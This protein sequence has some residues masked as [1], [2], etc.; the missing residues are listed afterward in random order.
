MH[1]AIADMDC[2]SDTKPIAANGIRLCKMV[3]VLHHEACPY[4]VALTIFT[5]YTLVFVVCG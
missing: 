3:Y 4:M 2:E 1:Y 5:C